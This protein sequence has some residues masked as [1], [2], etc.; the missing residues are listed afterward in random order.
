ME[1][2]RWVGLLAFSALYFQ[3]PVLFA[4]GLETFSVTVDTFAL[5]EFN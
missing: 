3:L 2:A 4:A 1:S 5:V